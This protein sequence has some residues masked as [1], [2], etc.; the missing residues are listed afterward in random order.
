M[1]ITEQHSTL[2]PPGK[3]QAGHRDSHLVA[4]AQAGSAEAF[5]ELESLYCKRLY[6]TI[7]GITKNREDAEDARQETFLRAYLSL[8]SFQ[9]RSS[10]YSWLTRIGINCALMVL[11]RHRGRPEDAFDPFAETEGG[12]SPFEV[13]D[14]RPDPEQVCDQQQRCMEIR[15]AIEG[16]KPT[17]RGPIQSRL[18]HG[19]SLGEIARAMNL[20]EAAVK[21]RIFRARAQLGA[22]RIFEKATGKGRL[23]SGLKSKGYLPLHQ[24]R[25]QAHSVI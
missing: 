14:P 8:H 18:A 9:G 4:A 12:N 6:R 2:N 1:I 13:R 24:N 17:L 21:S 20:S 7:F 11:R 19:S 3:E 22:A 15:Y 23:S 25:E 16:L 5:A 10:F